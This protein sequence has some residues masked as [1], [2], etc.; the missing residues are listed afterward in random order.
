M[1][2]VWDFF[3]QAGI[4]LIWPLRPLPGCR[5]WR[6]CRASC[7]SYFARIALDLGRLA[8]APRCGGN[9]SFYSGMVSVVGVLGLIFYV[10]AVLATKLFGSHADPSTR[11]GL[12]H[13][14]L[15]IR[16]SNHDT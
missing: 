16:L 12:H 8:N 10:S 1:P 4:G 2:I 11:N 3:A 5:M 13:Q 14:A 6:A 9:W 7:A 15:P